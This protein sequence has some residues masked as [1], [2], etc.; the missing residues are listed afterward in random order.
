MPAFQSALSCSHSTK[1]SLAITDLQRIKQP[2]LFSLPK[3]VS[4]F[5]YSHQLNM[6]LTGS[7]DRIIRVWCPYVPF[8]PTALLMGHDS[9]VVDVMVY[10]P[11]GV[12]LSIDTGGMVRIWDAVWNN[13]IQFVQLSFPLPANSWEFG[14]R[15]FF[16]GELG[17]SIRSTCA[18]YVASFGL[19]PAGDSEHQGLG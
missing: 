2:Y 19:V 4:C 18:N 1:V 8:K 9:F 14:P 10:F 13:C 12:F 16:T 15:I 7:V 6:L 11:K 5:C 3:G 17:R